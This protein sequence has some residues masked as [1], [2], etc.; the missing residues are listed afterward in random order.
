MGRA[1]ESTM[2]FCGIGRRYRNCFIVQVPNR[3]AETIVSIIEGFILPGT[4]IIT[5]CWRAYNRAERATELDL[6]YGTINH[7]LNFVGPK[8]LP[9]ILR[10]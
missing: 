4:I 6:E 5:D 8:I 2:V 3:R 1:C 10:T 7:G 9:F